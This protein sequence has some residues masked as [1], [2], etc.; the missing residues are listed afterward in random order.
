MY[1][2]TNTHAHMPVHAPSLCAQVRGQLVGCN[3]LLSLGEFQA[4]NWSLMAWE[5]VPLLDEPS[6][7][8]QITQ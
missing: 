3:S 7:W 8:P 1:V 6:Q 2:Y 4:P 5:Q